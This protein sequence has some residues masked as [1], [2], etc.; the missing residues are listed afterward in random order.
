MT[1]TLVLIRVVVR[2]MRV[3]LWYVVKRKCM[4]I[5]VVLLE[6]R[7]GVVIFT[8]KTYDDIINFVS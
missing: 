8:N 3:V 6:V 4:S 2:K 5:H 7:L 1:E